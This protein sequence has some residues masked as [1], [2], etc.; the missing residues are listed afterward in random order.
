MRYAII[1]DSQT[2]NTAQIAQAIRDALPAEECLAYIT[3]SEALTKPDSYAKADLI[4]YG[5][6]TERLSCSELSQLV[7]RKLP[8]TRIALFATAGFDEG[9]AYN[10]KIMDN[11][12]MHLPR[13]AKLAGT[14]TCIGKMPPSMLDEYIKLLQDP[15]TNEEAKYMLDNYEK[16]KNRPDQSD[17]TNAVAF[18]KRVYNA[19]K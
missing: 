12:M 16:V 3:S 10:Q 11:A 6:W 8:A 13:G 14:L 18:A 1:Y 5:F 9:P 4:F 19:I 2:G 17:F 7:I 15:A